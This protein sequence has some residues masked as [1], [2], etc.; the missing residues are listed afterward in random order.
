M[1]SLHA[2]FNQERREH[3]WLTFKQAWRI[4]HDHKKAKRK[5]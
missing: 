3:P 1:A 2:K 4:V 5:R